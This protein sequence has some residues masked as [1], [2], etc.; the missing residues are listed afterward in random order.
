MLWVT[1]GWLSTVEVSDVADADAE[2]PKEIPPKEFWE[3]PTPGVSK[4]GLGQ[5]SGIDP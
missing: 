1:D 3:A 2:P 5:R 4:P